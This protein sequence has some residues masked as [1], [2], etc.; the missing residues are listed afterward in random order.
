[1]KITVAPGRGRY[2]LYM[3]YCNGDRLRQTPVSILFTVIWNCVL[4][5]G[6]TGVGSIV[7]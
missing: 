6:L 4:D 3:M 1:M 5:E 7:N 2:S